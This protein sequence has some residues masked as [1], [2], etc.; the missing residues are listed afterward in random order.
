MDLL[1]FLDF[2]KFLPKSSG[3]SFGFWGFPKVFA[4]V[5]WRIFWIFG[6]SQSCCPGSLE[7]LLDCLIFSWKASEALRATATQRGCQLPRSRG[8]RGVQL[9]PR[10]GVSFEAHISNLEDA[11]T[12]TIKD[13]RKDQA[14]RDNTTSRQIC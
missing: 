2:L 4:H 3:E 1:L 12:Q 13:A 5:V 6:I 14:R 10:W 11:R 7:N 8:N 9:L